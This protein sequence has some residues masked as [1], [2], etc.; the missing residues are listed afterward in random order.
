VF[1]KNTALETESGNMFKIGE[2]EKLCKTWVS[3]KH[4]HTQPEDSCNQNIPF[5][6]HAR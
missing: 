3:V 1:V 6:I 5:A 4:F 2:R